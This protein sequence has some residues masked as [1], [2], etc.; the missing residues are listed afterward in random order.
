MAYEDSIYGMLCQVHRMAQSAAAK[1]LFELG[2]SPLEARVLLAIPDT[3]AVVATDIATSLDFPLSTVTRALRR[4]ESH[5]YVVIRKGT[6]RD[7]RAVLPKLT[8]EGR[9]IR[10]SVESFWDPM[11]RELTKGLKPVEVGVLYSAL[12]RLSR[13]GEGRSW[14]TGGEDLDAI[15]DAE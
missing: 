13:G 12:V 6:F 8:D 10:D 2:V 3:E 7:P 15:T 14:R 1:D 11:D 5:G 9:C 4:M